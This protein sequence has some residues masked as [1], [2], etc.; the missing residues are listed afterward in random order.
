MSTHFKHDE[1]FYVPCFQV[2][3]PYQD[4]EGQWH[5][6][7]NFTYSLSDGSRDPQMAAAMKPDYILVLKGT[8]DAKTQ[9]FDV[10]VFKH[11][12]GIGAGDRL[13]NI[14]PIEGPELCKHVPE[15]FMLNIEDPSKGGVIP[16]S[17]LTCA[18]CGA[19]IEARWEVVK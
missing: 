11:N 6:S 4:R 7:S 9:P 12:N 18:K 10:E 19:K 17:G 16:L 2:N 15:S 1:I 14:Q 5:V 8:F 13:F 3:E